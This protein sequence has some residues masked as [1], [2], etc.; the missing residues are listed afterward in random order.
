MHRTT[1]EGC[2]NFLKHDGANC[3][4]MEYCHLCGMAKHDGSVHLCTVEVVSLLARAG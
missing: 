4:F 1:I 3:R 2:H